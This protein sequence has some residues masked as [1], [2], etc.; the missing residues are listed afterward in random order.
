M[1]KK[2][3]NKM[4]SKKGVVAIGKGFK[5]TD[6]QQT[7]NLA[8]I[9]SVEKK[10]P[11]KYLNKKDVVPFE[12][13]GILTDVMETGKI[14]LQL[15]PILKH[16][17]APAGVSV[18]H[19]NITAGT[20]GIWVKKHDAD[21]NKWYMLS[22]NH[23]LANV[24]AGVVSD[25]IVQPGTYDGGMVSEDTIATLSEFIPITFAEV[26]SD[27]KVASAI[28]WFLNLISTI[29]L[30]RSTKLK[31]YANLDLE[32]YVD[33][34]LALPLNQNDVDTSI[35]D[36]GNH[37]GMTKK[38]ILGMKVQKSGRTSGVTTGEVS[39]VDVTVAV[40]MGDG[41]TAIFSDQVIA[42]GSMSSPGDSGSIVLDMEKN[43][44][45]LL[46]AGSDE[47]TVYNTIDRVIEA[48]NIRFK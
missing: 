20:L 31:P 6:G 37:T 16:R 32:N 48:L 10:V 18:G 26:P 45:G 27:C 3:A 44:V 22:N 7:K 13:N 12:I 33:C 21:D 19:Y 40:D 36:I 9:C 23:V 30:G 8:Y 15:N 39:Q 42:T 28:S 29:V 46:F 4:L 41:N 43:I 34:A 17:P 14:K 47:V 1:D 35:N 38:S 5:I 2:I 11:A 25:P 24:N